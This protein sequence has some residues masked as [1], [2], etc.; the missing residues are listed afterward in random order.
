MSEINNQGNEFLSFKNAQSGEIKKIALT[1]ENMKAKFK[2]IYFSVI[3]DFNLK[4]KD[5]FVSNEDGKM[6]GPFDFSLKLKEIIKRFG[7]ELKLYS[8]K[9]Q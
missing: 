6:I 1:P 4:H 2:N 3:K 8:E 9:V 7:K 5:I